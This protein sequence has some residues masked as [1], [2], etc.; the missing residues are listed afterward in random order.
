[1]GCNQ[2]GATETKEIRCKTLLYYL[3]RKIKTYD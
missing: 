3:I 1:M 2:S